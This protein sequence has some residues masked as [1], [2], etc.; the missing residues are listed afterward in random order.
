MEWLQKC[1]DGPVTYDDVLDSFRSDGDIDAIDAP[2]KPDRGMCGRC[3]RTR[4]IA[5]LSERRCIDRLSCSKAL[6][7]L[8][9]YI[10]NLPAY[11]KENPSG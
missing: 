1:S 8:R 5:A 11:K 6:L 9:K 7:S 10:N 3:L 4:P 2:R